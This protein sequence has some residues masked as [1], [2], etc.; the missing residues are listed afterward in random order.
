MDARKMI[1]TVRPVTGMSLS[2]RTNQISWKIGIRTKTCPSDVAIAASGTTLV[3]VAQ[4]AVV[5]MT[6]ASIGR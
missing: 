1:S 2:K 4:R 3:T 6:T 5:L